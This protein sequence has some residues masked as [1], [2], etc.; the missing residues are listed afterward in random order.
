M[1][2]RRTSR[3]L[4]DIWCFVPSTAKV[5]SVSDLPGNRIECDAVVLARLI[6]ESEECEEDEGTDDD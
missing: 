5:N 6:G 3:K 2:T 1:E 4:Y